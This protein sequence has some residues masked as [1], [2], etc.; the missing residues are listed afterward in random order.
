MLLMVAGAAVSAAFGVEGSLHPYKIRFEAM[1]HILDH[2]VRPNAKNLVSDFG[3]QMP[4]SQMPSKAHELIGVFMPDFDN[5][6]RSG[7]DLQQPAIIKLQAIAIGHR[8][9]L[10]KIEKDIFALIRSQANAAAMARVK[11]ERDRARRLFLRPMPGGAM[12]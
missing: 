1:E 2:M 11:I 10:R 4:I 9:R 5:T 7:L 3:G 6:L 12:N 8:N